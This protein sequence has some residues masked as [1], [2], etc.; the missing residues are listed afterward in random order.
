MTGLIHTTPCITVPE[1]VSLRLN[2][3]LRIL[4]DTRKV[5]IVSPDP[6]NWLHGHPTEPEARTILDEIEYLAHVLADAGHA[7]EAG[8]LRDV[9]ELATLSTD[10]GGLGLRPN[11][12]TLSEQ[13][14]SELLFL[15][16]AHLEAVNS[17]ER[18]KAP[19]KPLSQRPQGRRGMTLAEKVFAAHDIDQKGEVKP[20]DV[21]R[22]DVDWILASELSWKVSDGRPRGGHPSTNRISLSIRGWNDGTID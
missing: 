13:D 19:L 3:L 15:V 5:K 9:R 21:I 10:F 16:S 14:T 22:V 18:A 7:A 11:G 4:E 20:G 1:A 17:A 8:A 12:E 2:N 6:V